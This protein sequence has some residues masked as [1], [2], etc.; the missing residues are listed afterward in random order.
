[1]SAAVK[2]QSRLVGSKADSGA[3][4]GLVPVYKK[5]ITIGLSGFVPR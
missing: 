1:M 2:D 3:T 4:L 5:Q